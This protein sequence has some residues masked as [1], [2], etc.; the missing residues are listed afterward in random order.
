M[1][2]TKVKDDVRAFRAYLGAFRLAPEDQGIIDN[3]WRLAEKLG[4]YTRARTPTPVVVTKPMAKEASK[5][6]RTEA[7][8]KSS[9]DIP[10]ASEEIERLTGAEPGTELDQD[11][12]TGEIDLNDVDI[13]IDEEEAA[14]AAARTPPPV[15]GVPIV[16]ESPWQEWVHAYEMLAAPT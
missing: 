16:F 1:V 4:S 10:L 6:A 13:V 11:D 7:K 2:E 14:E 12:I 8:A 3:L 15:Q 5:A 9:A